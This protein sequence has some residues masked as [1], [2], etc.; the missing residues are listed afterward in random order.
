MSIENP[1]FENKP[2]EEPINDFPEENGVEEKDKA[3]EKQEEA[4]EGNFEEMA[5]DI[6]TRL[7]DIWIGGDREG[8]DVFTTA[9]NSDEVMQEV[10][11]TIQQATKE[12]WSEDQLR[13]KLGGI[14]VKMDTEHARNLMQGARLDPKIKSEMPLRDIFISGW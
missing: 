12:K 4:P 1:S 11:Q 5:E 9:E 3:E 6:K 13:K 10:N 7:E 8:E 2:E 14:K